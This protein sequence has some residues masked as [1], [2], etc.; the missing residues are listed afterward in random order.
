MAGIGF[1]PP[2]GL[3][4]GI[5]FDEGIVFPAGIDEFAAGAELAA[6]IAF[7]PCIM[8]GDAL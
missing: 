6:D 1:S 3:P 4:V 8:D 2:I 7:D 5:W